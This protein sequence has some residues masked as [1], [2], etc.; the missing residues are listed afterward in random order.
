M[1]GRASAS[2]VVAFVPLASL[3]SLVS[4]VSACGETPP[5]NDATKPASSASAT[6]TAGS[7]AAASK[8]ACEGTTVR[9]A[10]KEYCVVKDRRSFDQAA[11]ECTRMRG[12]LAVLDSAD[13]AKALAAQ[14]VSPW[15]YGS[16]MW[17]GCSDGDDEGKWKCNGQPM[18][19]AN[20]AP[21][22]PDSETALDDC[23]QWLADS[24]QW[25]DASCA[26]K[27][28]YVCRG[29]ASMKCSG[30]KITAGSSV[31]CAR[32][33]DQQ[34]WDGAKKACETAGGKLAT[35]AN[36]DE[37]RALFD[38]LKLASA[39]P[40]VQPS[41]GVWIGLTDQKEEGKWRWSNDAALAAASWMPGQPDDANGGE[42]CATLTLG[43]GR[44]N[45]VDCIR[46]LPFVCE[47]K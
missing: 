17:L 45:D 18:T 2:I 31:F 7:S 10:S 16:A 22:K 5:P 24:G 38:S 13:E 32:G 42:D 28:G 44:W 41:E 1:P 14:L 8:M 29:D 9:T 27:L 12:R 30:K 15:G 21:G 3:A 36:A 6:A 4:L 26:W 34:D 23:A 25:N 37:S 11:S 33:D 19:Y 20:W 40:S 43:D 35:P 46:G 39:I 47:A